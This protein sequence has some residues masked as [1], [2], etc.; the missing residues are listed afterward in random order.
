MR[1]AAAILAVLLALASLGACKEVPDGGGGPPR[2]GSSGKPK[3]GPRTVVLTVTVSSTHPDAIVSWVVSSRKPRGDVDAVKGLSYTKRLEIVEGRDILVTFNISNPR[4]LTS[5]TN[6][7][8][9]TVR[10]GLTKAHEVGGG[11]Q[12]C[13]QTVAALLDDQPH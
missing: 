13:V 5:A 7:C 11:P 8:R 6:E 1:R 3:A 4:H 10:G 2:A 12:V 9:F